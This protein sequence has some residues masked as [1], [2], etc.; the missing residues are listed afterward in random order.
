VGAVIVAFVGVVIDFM[1]PGTVAPAA[2]NVIDSPP[3][4]SGVATMN[5]LYAFSAVGVSV[6]AC[7][8][9]VIVIVPALTAAG[10][11]CGHVAISHAPIVWLVVQNAPLEKKLALAVPPRVGVFGAFIAS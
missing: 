7:A 5:V 2:A 6:I 1:K 4:N 9:P 11:A 3:L 8:A 10:V